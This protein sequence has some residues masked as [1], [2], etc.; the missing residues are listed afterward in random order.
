MNDD[1]MIFMILLILIL[2]SISF[3]YIIEDE[4]DSLIRKIKNKPVETPEQ[5]I[6]L[7]LKETSSCLNDYICSI[8]KYKSRKDYEKPTLQELIDDGGDCKNWAELYESYALE[9][10]F[11]SEVIIIDTSDESKHAF[12]IISDE[13][14]YCKLDQMNLDCFMFGN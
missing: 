1:L 12:T 2:S 8:F 5:C 4:I 14:G 11:Y 6:N 7:S 9:L 13:T 10:D 3:G